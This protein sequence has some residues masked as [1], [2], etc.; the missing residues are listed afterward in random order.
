VRCQ[1]CTKIAGVFIDFAKACVDVRVCIVFAMECMERG[2]AIKGTSLG[3]QRSEREYSV[4]YRAKVW[5]RLT[6]RARVRARVSGGVTV[7]VTVSVTNLLHLGEEGGGRKHRK[8]ELRR[9]VVS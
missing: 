1:G 4:F 9:A 8:E 6:V 5:V 3:G 7:A 2:F